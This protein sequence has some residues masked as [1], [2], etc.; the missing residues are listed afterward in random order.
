MLA[1]VPF[2]LLLAAIVVP[3]QYVFRLLTGKSW[4]TKDLFFTDD[5]LVILENATNS[6][7]PI[8]VNGIV[9]ALK[10]FEIK[11]YIRHSCE[12]CPDELYVNDVFDRPCLSASRE[13]GANLWKISCSQPV[14][15]GLLGH[16]GADLETLSVEGRSLGKTEI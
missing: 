11:S 16:I 8:F 12:S 9:R 7:A 10:P 14:L 6:G 4:E 3:I 5:E 1:G 15:W 13:I 2:V